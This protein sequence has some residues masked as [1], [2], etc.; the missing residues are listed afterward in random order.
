MRQVERA[1]EVAVEVVPLGQR[2]DED[3]AAREDLLRELLTGDLAVHGNLLRK[4]VDRVMIA[5]AIN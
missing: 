2:F 5:N 1:G 3:N 4:V